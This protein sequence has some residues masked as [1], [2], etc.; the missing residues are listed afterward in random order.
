MT[1]SPPD[2]SFTVEDFENNVEDTPNDDIQRAEP[3]LL[4]ENTLSTELSSTST[5]QSIDPYSL[6]RHS[7][8]RKPE[9]RSPI[10]GSLFATT[11]LMVF[12]LLIVLFLLIP[13]Q[14]TAV[15][16]GEVNTYSPSFRPQKID[17]PVDGVIVEWMIA[18]GALVK[19]GDVLLRLQNNDPELLN[20][21]LEGVELGNAQISNTNDKIALY[22]EKY[23]IEKDAIARKIAEISDKI[24]SLQDKWTAAKI[25]FETESIQL[26]RYQDLIK[27]GIVSQRDVEL[28]KLK[29]SKAIAN[30]DALQRQ[31]NALNNEKQRVELEGQS[32]LTE[33]QAN[34]TDLKSKVA[35]GQQ[36][37]L[38]LQSKAVQQQTQDIV[39]PMD[40][41]VHKLIGG[42]QGEQVKKGKTLLSFVP[43]STDRAVLLEVNGNDVAL[44]HAE[45]E[46]RLIF[47]GWPALQFIGFPGSGAGTFAGTIQMIEPA[48]YDEGKFRVWITPDSSEPDWPSADRLRL[49]L[50]VKG[51]VILGT[52]PLGYEIWRQINGFP[53]PP[54]IEKGEKPALPSTKKSKKV[55]GTP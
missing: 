17:S 19:K 37:Q 16:K 25:E 13:W 2:D 34:I 1:T 18:E 33:I 10:S 4:D 3:L 41:I 43:E 28:A 50:R 24:Q 32:K 35:S 51:W 27:E 55:L 11:A 44:L 22:Q 31:I 39:A 8:L 15:G 12:P 46:V 23:N 20:R 30:R 49:G 48:A 47:E 36:K 21:M 53:I 52:V 6:Q 42:L 40:G 38:E 54:N 5:V 45:Q 7:L 14:Q 29:Q 9:V 26:N